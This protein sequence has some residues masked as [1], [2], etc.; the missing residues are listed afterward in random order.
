MHTDDVRKV[1]DRIL[2]MIGGTMESKRIEND[3]Y[4]FIDV[5]VLL[6]KITGKDGSISRYIDQVCVY[7]RGVANQVI[8]IADEGVLVESS[9]PQNIINKFKLYGISKEEVS[10]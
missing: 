8:M 4:T 3:I 5:A 10:W 7:D 1:P 6:R 9:L 2:N